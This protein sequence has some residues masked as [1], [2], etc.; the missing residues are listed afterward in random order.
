MYRLLLFLRR[1]HV[2]VIFL[3][4]EG[5]ALHYYANSTV[6]SRARLLGA[7]DRVVGSV[8]G[9]IAG[10]GHFT[11]L[12]A[13]NRMLEENVAALENEL[14]GYREIFAR[15][16]LDSVK[17]TAPQP[18]EYM[19]AGVVRNSINKRENYLTID[20]G[21]RD[22]V[23]RGMAVVSTDGCMVGYVEG[24]SAGSAICV[25]VLGTDFRA[26][27]MFAHTGHFG[28]ISWPGGDPRTVRL[29]EVPK[30]AEVERGDTIITRSSINFPEGITIGTVESFTTDEA[31]ALYDID[32]RLGAD[33]SALRVVLLVKDPGTREQIEL[34][35]EVLGTAA[36]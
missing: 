27:G 10:A 31:R 9:A 30:Y 22:G 18:H 7:S 12:G 17:I 21:S 32:V 3:A 28:S 34:E 11:S 19:V 16:G 5:L 26:T 1:I 35:E 13:T 24:V 20:R 8:Y 36:E 15:T 2:L 25:S 6:H 23:E 33:I 14:A 29:S 4:L